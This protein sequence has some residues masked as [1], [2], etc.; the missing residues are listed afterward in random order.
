[1]LF[2]LFTKSQSTHDISNGLRS[3][4]VNLNHLSI[5]SAPSKFTVNY[6]NKNRS[7]KFFRDY[8]Y[9]SQDS[10]GHKDISS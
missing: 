4:T 7:W 9:V 3:V 5:E 1:M 2:C 10:L 8:F 6:Q